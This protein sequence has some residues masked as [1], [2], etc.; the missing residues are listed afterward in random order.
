[1]CSAVSGAVAAEFGDAYD[2]RFIKRSYNI[3]E[4]TEYLKQGCAVVSYVPGHYV[5]I[6]DY[7]EEEETYLVLDSHPIPRRPTSPWGDWFKKDKFQS[8]GLKYSCFFIF[9][10]VKD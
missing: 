8:G 6:A 5:T 2:F 3:Y 10:K 1:M 9:E 7:N 4:M